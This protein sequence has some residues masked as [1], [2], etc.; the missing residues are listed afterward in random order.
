MAENTAAIFGLVLNMPEL[1]G[2]RYQQKVSLDTENLATLQAAEAALRKDGKLGNSKRIVW[3]RPGHE[4][5]YTAS[6]LE[7]ALPGSGKEVGNKI[8]VVLLDD[9]G[10][11]RCLGVVSAEAKA[12][13][14]K[15]KLESLQE[16]AAAVKENK[17]MMELLRSLKVNTNLS[18]L[19]IVQKITGQEISVGFGAALAAMQSNTDEK[20][21]SRSSKLASANKEEKKKVLAKPDEDDFDGSED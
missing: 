20:Q 15:A 7:A 17:K 11:G 12:K 18:Q 6:S 9:N 4:Y 2:N 8:E 16:Q 14:D 10:W 3:G 13:A 5:V 19:A 21:V 1:S